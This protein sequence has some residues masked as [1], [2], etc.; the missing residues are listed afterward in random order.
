MAAQINER[1]FPRVNIPDEMQVHFSFH[2]DRY[3]LSFPQITEVDTGDMGDLM[4]NTNPWNLS[5]L[6]DQ[7]AAWINTCASGYRLVIFKDVNLS[8]VEEKV[9]AQTGKTLFLPST[10]GSFPEQEPYPHER[11]ITESMFKKYLGSTGV[12]AAFAGT[13]CSRFVKA[14]A[15]MGILSDAWV[16]ILFQDYVIGYIH[17]W[18]SDAQRQLFD[19][20]VVDTLHQFSKVLTHSMKIN[21]Y[22]NDKVPAADSFDGKIVDISASGLLFACPLSGFVSSLL[23]ESELDISISTP[24]REIFLKAHVVRCFNDAMNSYVGCK[25]HNVPEGDFN[26]LFGYI[27]G[28]P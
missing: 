27:Y 16:P 25:F 26:F 1:T 13:A 9:I 17:I 2:G 12:G 14:K 28:N 11:I 21:G 8:T 10:K 7:M 20:S 22:F 4:K 6:I 15:D 23:P 24:P 18:N 3:N 19:F 5:G